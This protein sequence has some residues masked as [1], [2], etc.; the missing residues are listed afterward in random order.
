MLAAAELA[1]INGTTQPILDL[2]VQTAERF[3]LHHYVSWE[4]HEIP[5]VGAQL[6]VLDGVLN[7]RLALY[8]PAGWL[9]L[10]VLRFY[11]KGEDPPEAET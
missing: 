3:Y 1:L 9:S 6:I 5:G 8:Q 7:A 4:T 10:E 11:R 2:K